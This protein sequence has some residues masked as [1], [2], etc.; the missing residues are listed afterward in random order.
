MRGVKSECGS[1]FVNGGADGLHV[2]VLVFKPLTGRSVFQAAFGN[3]AALLQMLLISSGSETP[4]ARV[5]SWCCASCGTAP[6]S[7]AHP[8]SGRTGG[9]GGARTLGPAWAPL[10]GAF[11][12]LGQSKGSISGQF[13]APINKR[14]SKSSWQAPIGKGVKK[15]QGADFAW[16]QFPVVSV[17]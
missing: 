6:S 3:P 13:P 14:T 4:A 15:G 8:G 1:A 9:T 7:S 17:G 10:L 16:V 12:E 11:P 2:C 5:G